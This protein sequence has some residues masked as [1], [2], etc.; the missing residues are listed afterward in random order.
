MCRCFDK[1]NIDDISRHF[2]RWYFSLIMFILFGASSLLLHPFA[3]RLSVCVFVVLRRATCQVHLRDGPAFTSFRAATLMEK[4]HKKFAFL[5]S[6][7][8]LT[9]SQP[10][11][12]LTP[13]H[14]VFGRVCTAIP[15]F[16][17]RVGLDLEV[18]QHTS[19]LYQSTIPLQTFTSQPY[20]YRPLPVNHTFTD[21]YQST[22]PL[23]TFTSQPYLYRPLP[24]NHTFTDLYQSTIPL[25]TFTSQ[26]YL[27]RPLPGNHT[28][29]D[30]YQ[31]TIPLQTFT[32][33]PYL[34][35][36]L[37]VNHT[38]TR[39]FTSQ[40]YLYRPLPV[41]HTFTDLYQ[42]TIPLHTFT[43]QPYL[44]RPLPVNHTFTDLYQSTIPL[45][46][47]TSQP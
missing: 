11:L 47:F 19:D 16:K 41:N 44:Y 13:Y 20:L 27:Y 36:P 39:L 1:A 31:S 12:P 45:Y 2:C 17:S 18:I 3:E 10:V 33:Q 26:P 14:Q 21:L 43:S 15:I 42:S 35:R 8:V 22:I 4:L 37:P 28:F 5:T 34:Y 30:L 9:P 7:S 40:P 23:Q 38:F 6:H 29:A 46:T 24:V 32:S 25:Q